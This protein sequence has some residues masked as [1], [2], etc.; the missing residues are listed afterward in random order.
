VFGVPVLMILAAMT[1]KAA[2]GVAITSSG[3]FYACVLACHR[4]PARI[5]APARPNTATPV[6]RLSGGSGERPVGGRALQ[7]G[8]PDAGHATA[9]DVHS[10]E[11]VV[12]SLIRSVGFR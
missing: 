3:S 6:R 4:H 1:V 7:C 9:A 2:V 11:R 12:D 8:Q 10:A 5:I